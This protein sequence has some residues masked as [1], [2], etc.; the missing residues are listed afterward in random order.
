MKITFFEFENQHQP[1]F[2]C[3]THEHELVFTSAALNSNTVERHTDTHV[4][5]TLN[6]SVLSEAILSQLPA[7][8]LIISRTTGFDHIALDYCRQRN[9]TVTYVPHYGQHTV[10]EHT[11]SLLLT[12]SHQL[13]AE[14]ARPRRGDFSP[15]GARGFDLF[16]KTMGIIG[17][18][19]IGRNTL[20]IAR[21]FNMPV[22]G[23]DIAPDMELAK[24]FAF[25]YV[26]K[27]QLLAESDIITLHLP[28]DESTFNFISASEFKR[29]KPGAILINT[30]RGSIVDIMALADALLSG[31]L[32]GACLDVL[33]HE[34][35]LRNRD[36]LHQALLDSS[37]LTRELLTIRSLL[38]LPNVVMTPHTAYN[39]KEAV[40]RI[41]TTTRENIE[42]FLSGSPINTVPV[43]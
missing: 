29:M 9:I 11:F 3:L 38:D 10:A 42:G 15:K 21:G 1:L 30:A 20:R 36:A 35:I 39:T 19:N 6:E 25:E 34:T 18:G 16:G 13:T 14:L 26:S 4:I 33:P 22:L 41:L 7:L 5:A 32:G 37:P 31:T 28:G 8:R 2:D 27:E 12:L 40:E 24:K 43:L 17:V 23:H